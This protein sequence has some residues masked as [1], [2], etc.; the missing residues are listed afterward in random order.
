MI[1][2]LITKLNYDHYKTLSKDYPVWIF[3]AGYFAKSLA[4]ILIDKGYNLQG[5]VVSNQSSILEIFDKP[6]TT[7]KH[8]IKGQV[9][10]GIY[11]QNYSYQK[12]LLEIQDNCDA[13]IFMPWEIYDQFHQE[14]GWRYWLTTKNYYNTNINYIE[15]VYN[16][17]ADKESKDCLI[18]TCLFRIGLNNEY[19][20]YQSQ[21]SHYF[22]QLTLERFKNSPLTFVDGGAFIGDSY[23]DLLSKHPIKQA[24]LFEPDTENY[25]KMTNI[26]KGNAVC[27]PL[28]IS[29]K[30]Q[31]LS[32]NSN[33]GPSSTVSTSGNTFISAVSLD[34]MLPD[35]DIDLIKLD[36]EG[37]EA[38][39][40]LG[41]KNIIKRCRP[42]LTMALYHKP[43]DLWELPLL[44][45][46]MCDNYE[47]Y[48]RQHEYN[49]FESVLYAVAR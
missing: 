2:D 17:L 27:L 48:I 13:D 21:E 38:A 47:F 33:I 41:T 16:L 26:V 25:L 43:G 31:T 14:L 46:N 32:F 24:F 40:I 23:I 36:I 8:G 1:Q 49:S 3:G 4:K 9:V 6:V 35:V 19:A 29:D 28:A 5:F 30:Y 37:S 10:M 20:E 34:Q 11:N 44:L 42:N 45:S 15:K 18:N 39:A 7:W 12:L 22:N